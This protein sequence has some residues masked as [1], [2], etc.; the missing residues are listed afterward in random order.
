MGV[1]V[2]RDGWVGEE[3]YI[4]DYGSMDKRVELENAFNHMRRNDSTKSL[5]ISAKSSEH[6][7][8][9]KQQQLM[10]V[11]EDGDQGRTI[12]PVRSVSPRTELSSPRVVPT[13]PTP[14]TPG[15]RLSVSGI[16]ESLTLTARPRRFSSSTTNGTLPLSDPSR[17]LPFLRSSEMPVF[18][19]C[20]FKAVRRT[21]PRQ[22]LP[23]ATRDKTKVKLRFL[24]L[25]KT[26]LLCVKDADGESIQTSG[27]LI[28]GQ[29]GGHGVVL[30]V[31]RA[32]QGFVVQTAAKSYAYATEDAALAMRWIK[33]IGDAL[34]VKENSDGDRTSIVSDRTRSV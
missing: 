9:P 12:T 2:N 3:E 17:W 6:Q 24:I 8:P 16:F 14:S 1:G 19:S 29:G 25:T 13:E 26:R 5:S 34:P 7:P 22:L 21:F 28:G 27:I 30:G 33:E 10:V 18:S 15:R 23:V 32:E 11:N 4:E 31:E 20:V